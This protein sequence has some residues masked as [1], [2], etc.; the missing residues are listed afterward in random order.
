[1]S[2]PDERERGRAKG[3]SRN[4]GKDPAE[5]FE[6]SAD[7]AAAADAQQTINE[8]ES[9]IEEE[10]E[11]EADAGAAA[12]EPEAS[13]SD[14]QVAASGAA[15]AAAA[16]V[17]ATE[18]T[19]SADISIEG[20]TTFSKGELQNP[21]IA[22]QVGERYGLSEEGIE[23]LQTLGADDLTPDAPDTVNLD[24][25]TT[26]QP[27]SD[28]D[29]QTGANS[30]VMWVAETDDGD[31]M[32]V[33]FD[34][35]DAESYP[36]EGA[37]IANSLAESLPEDRREQVG[38]PTIYT[39]HKRGAS[40]LEDVGA[41]DSRSAGTYMNYDVDFEKDD[42]LAAVGA[43][44]LAGDNDISGNIVTSSETTFHPIDFDA[45]GRDIARIDERKAESDGLYSDADGL[46]D[47]L[48]TQTSRTMALYDFD[49]EDG[50]LRSATQE[51]AETVDTDT[52]EANLK[53]IETLSISDRD[54]I[55]ENIQRVKDGDI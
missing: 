15:A 17:Q 7:S 30:Q 34:S 42:Y 26:F 25:A 1:M 33:T 14:D 53:Q 2:S 6:D 29:N 50:D 16:N 40:V 45:A 23:Q 4:G 49:I 5:D 18:E 51:L 52:L 12:D 11:A 28:T 43:K 21:E 27:L 22:R 48:E 31:Q 35:P 32:F 20:Q 3:S 13:E 44:I 54:T 8:I 37:E 10:A 41:D 36:L 38:F 24:N 55:L 47:Q 9:N 39:D 19:E 46:F